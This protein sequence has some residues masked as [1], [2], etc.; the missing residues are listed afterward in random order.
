MLVEYAVL[1]IITLSGL[2]AKLPAFYEMGTG[3]GL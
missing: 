2:L 1:E 3:S